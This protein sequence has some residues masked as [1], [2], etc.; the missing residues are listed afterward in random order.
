MSLSEGE[1]LRDQRLGFK[2]RRRRPAALLTVTAPSIQYGIHNRSTAPDSHL[3]G[4]AAGGI[5]DDPGGET[6]W[7]PAPQPSRHGS[8]EERTTS[9]AG[10]QRDRCDVDKGP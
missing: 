3:V 1:K 9:Q 6:T 10:T 8:R 5:K 7:H 4:W 2:Q